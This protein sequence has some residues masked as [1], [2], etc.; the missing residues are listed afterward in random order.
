MPAGVDAGDELDQ[1][2]ARGGEGGVAGYELG[3]GTIAVRDYGERECRLVWGED[4]EIV[5]AGLRFVPRDEESIRGD[6]Q[7]IIVV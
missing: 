2:V 3:P 4:R 6:E 7:P 5:L 1:F